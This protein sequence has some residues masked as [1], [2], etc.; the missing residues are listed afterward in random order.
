MLFQGARTIKDKWKIVVVS[1]TTFSITWQEKQSVS[2]SARHVMHNL[3]GNKC[4]CF[5]CALYEWNGS[6]NGSNSHSEQK[7]KDNNK[8]SRK[9]LMLIMFVF[10]DKKSAKDFNISLGPGT[11]R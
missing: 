10:P 5:C 3:M 6:W 1:W 11:G 2:H 7:E 8:Q 9:S 4:I